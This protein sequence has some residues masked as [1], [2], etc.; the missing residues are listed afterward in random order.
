MPGPPPSRVLVLRI[1]REEDP[2]AGTLEEEGRPPHPF[3][4]W[5]GLARAMERVLGD[6]PP[7]PADPPPDQR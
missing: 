3:R 6:G 7:A 1:E 2:I 4:G 5:L